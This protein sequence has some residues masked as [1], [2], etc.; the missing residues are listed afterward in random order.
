MKVIEIKEKIKVG[1]VISYVPED[2]SL[3]RL[4][5]IVTAVTDK[6]ITSENYPFRDIHHLMPFSRLEEIIKKYYENKIAIYINDNKVK[7]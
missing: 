4:P 5:E 1:D 2:C 6:F 7:I 3:N